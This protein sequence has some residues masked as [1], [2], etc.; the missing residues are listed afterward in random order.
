VGP[1]SPFEFTRCF[2]LTDD[3]TYRLSH[4]S[5]TS[6]IWMLPSPPS[7]RCSSSNAATTLSFHSGRQLATLRAQHRSRSRGFG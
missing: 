7:C 5:L 2:N 1:I 4:I 3:L 6:S